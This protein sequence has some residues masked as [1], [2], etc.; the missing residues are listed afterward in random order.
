MSHFFSFPL[1]ARLRYSRIQRRC[2]GRRK[3]ASLD[4]KSTRLNSSHL[5]IS[6]AV[7]CL[8]K[9]IKMIG[10]QWTEASRNRVKIILLAF[11]IACRLER[12]AEKPQ[13][14]AFPVQGVSAD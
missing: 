11:I 10:R 1:I 3:C 12:P 7:F 14:P 8:K 5:G 6:Y 2:L 13:P 4:R 9:K